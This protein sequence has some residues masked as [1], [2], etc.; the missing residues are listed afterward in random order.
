MDIR[1][2]DF[3]ESSKS[4]KARSEILNLLWGIKVFTI[5]DLVLKKEIDLLRIHGFG[6][7]FLEYLKTAL[8]KKG[9]NLR[10]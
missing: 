7:K 4:L 6:A 8:E 5:E 2:L 3:S 1:Q 10:K 9:K